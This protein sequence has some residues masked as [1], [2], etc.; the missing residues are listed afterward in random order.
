MK[1]AI[2]VRV[3]TDRQD[4]ERQLNELKTFAKRNNIDIPDKY[5]FE[6]KISGFKTEEERPEFNK[7]MQL[8]KEDIDI[9]LIWELSRL[10]R[11]A[12]LI[13]TY[14]EQ[15]NDKGINLYI[16]D[17]NLYTL[18][19]TGEEDEQTKLIVAIIST[20]AE[21]EVRGTKER[22]KSSKNNKILNEKNSYTVKPP[23][24]YDVIDKKLIINTEERKIVRQ[25][26][27]LSLK[28]Y[29]C[30][31]IAMYLN[32]LPNPIKTKSSSFIKKDSF[33]INKHKVISKDSV[34]WTSGTINA[35]LK[36]TVYFGKAKYSVAYKYIQ[37]ES[38]K[39]K[40]KVNTYTYVDVPPIISQ[41]VFDRCKEKLKERKIISKSSRPTGFLLRG[42]IVCSI[43]GSK[44]VGNRSSGLYCCN[45][46][47]KDTPN[48]DSKCNAKTMSINKLE[49]I[50]WNIVE[51][52]YSN[53]L[54][55]ENDQAKII[56]IAKENKTLKDRIEGI[57][58]AI[59]K[60]NK[61]VENI[62]EAIIPIKDKF[63]AIYNK[64]MKEIDS[65]Y[66]DINDYNSEIKALQNQITLN[67]ERIKAINEG[68]SVKK[69]IASISN[70]ERQK[71]EIVHRV[72]NDI[73]IFK[74]DRST[75]IIDISFK[76]GQN[77]FIIYYSYKDYYLFIHSQNIKYNRITK[78]I[79]VELPKDK[80]SMRNFN[81]LTNT[82][83]YTL[84]EF[85]SIY[86]DNNFKTYYS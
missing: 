18:K 13:Q 22:F 86:D 51:K 4:Y 64:K 34:K 47:F 6:E 54:K 14:I 12:Y 26:F 31:R 81:F 49:Y 25:I 66:R 70:D 19:E 82:H 67:N 75:A 69:I 73:M 62:I 45:S 27:Y 84:H 17:R 63:P 48:K 71:S 65:Y 33:Q 83:T 85:L 3:S 21:Q 1:G 55:V 24:G 43:C 53:N 79:E 77:V 78:K 72:I 7:L 37:D 20:L 10:S 29:S 40:K 9:I 50:I 35:L 36:N 5:V 52:M 23:F 32:S 44:Y 61:E 46:K 57:N 76:T 80:T 38:K 16:K 15:L 42:L 74:E 41:Q 2:Y 30:K 11:K 56:P 39:N 8:T 68:E 28:G 59:A 60:L 58:S